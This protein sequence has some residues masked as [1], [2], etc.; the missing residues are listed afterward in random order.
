M[1]LSLSL[2][3]S[4]PAGIHYGL[5]SQI[6]EIVD[7]FLISRARITIR[8]GNLHRTLRSCP[9]LWQTPMRILSASCSGPQV[10]GE[11]NVN[12]STYHKHSQAREPATALGQ[13][14]QIPGCLW[15]YVE[16]RSSLIFEEILYFYS[17]GE[18]VAPNT[19]ASK[20][21][22]ASGQ[23]ALSL[24][25]EVNNPSRYAESSHTSPFTSTE[26][27]LRPTVCSGLRSISY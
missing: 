3:S 12:T 16:A 17:F 7:I 5:E 22:L 11:N 1:S 2:C 18:D 24:R 23:I 20:V 4:T 26:N 8:K 19:V 14:L 21:H 10:S 15:R 25:P 6:K 9:H 13:M 27:N